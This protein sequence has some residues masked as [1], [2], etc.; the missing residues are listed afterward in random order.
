MGA[1]SEIVVLLRE[2]PLL[3]GLDDEQLKRLAAVGTEKLVPAGEVNG[4]EGQPVEDLY[5]ILSGD[6]RI[7]KNVNGG[8]VTINTYRAGDFFAE[9][10]LL[11]GTPFQATGRAL[12]DIRL[13]LIP[14][15]EFRRML[16]AHPSFGHTILETM[17][18]RVQILQ[19]IAGQ[20]ERL[21]SLG[22]LAA[23]LAHELNN[24][25]SAARRAAGRLGE[26]LRETSVLGFALARSAASGGLEAA[27]LDA[28]ESVVDEAL[29]R[30]AD[31]EG[32]P[33]SPLELNEREEEM[34]TAL[35]DAGVEDAWEVSPAFVGAG[36]DAS[37]LSEAA[38]RLPEGFRAETLGYLGTVLG[39][40]GLV[41]EV[42]A[43]AARVSALVGAMKSYSYMDEAPLQEVDVN[44]GLESTLAVLGYKL[45]GVDV[46]REYDPRLPRIT[47]YGGELNQA[48]TQMVDNAVDA[49]RSGR[50]PGERGR[51]GLRTTCERDRVLV[52]I[53]D[54]GPGIPEE[55]QNR[56][57]EP[58]FTTKGVGAGTGL[59]LDLSYRVVVG[60]HGGD[61]RV[62]SR[63]GET[64]FQVRL[65]LAVGGP[66]EGPVGAAVDGLT[67]DALEAR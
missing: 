35:E 38:G 28:L 7:T 19:S 9:V 50:G 67:G 31:R 40:A 8:E 18:Q 25:A 42:E 3:A 4:R 63:P 48:W 46:A 62:E 45:E 41:G 33:L 15:S 56:V 61:I 13:F 26:S 14:E 64:R 55:I 36:L 57:F 53:S 5:V 11:A 22:T 6:L 60:R 20:R 52:E 51:I 17:A 59:G 44:E 30:A 16:N 10:P 47:A 24:P 27:D 39:A 49:A 21:D 29:I 12:T 37:W 43:G 32:A 34:S 1:T 2:V 54:D 58:F 65:P 23:G 66:V